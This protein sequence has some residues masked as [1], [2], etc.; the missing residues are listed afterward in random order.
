[1]DRLRN[2]V[3]YMVALALLVSAVN[4][5]PPLAAS[6]EGGGPIFL[7]AVFADYY[8]GPWPPQY[9]SIIHHG[10]E[11]GTVTSLAESTIRQGVVY[12]GSWGAGVFISYNDGVSWNFANQGLTNP[13]IYSLALDPTDP[14]VLYA[15]TF[16]DGV[17]K[18]ID[19]GTTWNP[20][21]PGLNNSAVVY[22][23]AISPKNPDVI[24]AGTRGDSTT[25]NTTFCNGY[26]SAGIA[27]FDGG[28]GVYR[29]TNG[30]GTW[31]KVD[32]GEACGYVYGLAIDPQNSNNIYVATHQVGVLKSVDGGTSF[33]RVNKG[34][35][36][37]STRSIIVDPDHPATLYVATW[38]DEGVAVSY[39]SGG[40][41]SAFNSGI[42]RE[43]VIR[44]DLD[45]ASGNR[46][47]LVWGHGLYRLAK[48][49]S[50]WIATGA[51][52]YSPYDMAISKID[53]S[54]LLF[55]LSNQG[56][57]LSA[58][59]GDS[60]APSNS[61]LYNVD[62]NT[63]LVDP[64]SPSTLYAGTG[65]L[66]VYKSGDNG[67]TWVPM[68]DGLPGNT[69]GSYVSIASMAADPAHP[70][71]FYAGTNG[72]GIYKTTDGGTSWEWTNVGL[73]STSTD[74][75]QQDTT[76]PPLPHPQ[77]VDPFFLD[78]AGQATIQSPINP[79]VGPWTIP[80]LAIDP[81]DPAIVY[82]GSGKG[83]YKTTNHGAS[84]VSSGLTGQAVFSLAINPQ[85]PAMLYAGTP[86]GIYQTFTGGSIWYP[87]GLAG[88]LIY[89]LALDPSQP[90]IL[91]AGTSAQGI[92]RSNDGGLTWL[93]DNQGLADS[94]VYSVVVDPAQPLFQYA[95]TAGGFFRSTKGG[96]SWEP[97]QMDPFFTYVDPVAANPSTPE[98]L[99]LGT[100]AG[101]VVVR[102]YDQPLKNIFLPQILA[103]T[104]RAFY[105]YP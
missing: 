30:G 21:G 43:P 69:N 15:G 83:L 48:G 84:W 40:N 47:A 51:G 2:V 60:W 39:N 86:D 102:F 105:P 67:F 52:G 63:L 94:C 24:F 78:D 74:L 57:Y 32:G 8:A 50:T 79:A 19:G 6:A 54:R 66:G 5:Q 44:L 82:A 85:D 31:S 80:A 64:F 1:M 45:P 70:G 93:S 41:W 104:Q 38:H 65:A 3:N 16:R 97:V 42:S 77:V 4:V 58:N 75:E 28:G 49:A 96:T 95:A 18:S 73:S 89:S 56:V 11:G 10:P 59:Y 99:Y 37:R 61:G 101:T 13:Y 71:E 36:D 23:L 9:Y 81:S 100:N 25:Y 33:V 46:Y 35:T 26:D 14:N 92:F 22:A 27:I 20:T 90:D 7:P 91:Y 17:F 34:L 76:S 12:A 53:S 88:N 68:R 103:Q 72:S 87:V 62:M 98:I 29:S 55:G